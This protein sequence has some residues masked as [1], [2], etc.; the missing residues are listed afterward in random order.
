MLRFEDI[1][2]LLSGR[3]L[4]ANECNNDKR[5]LPYLIGASNI[6][7]KQIQIS[8]WTEFAKVISERGDILL[9]CKGTVGEIVLNTVGPIHIARQFMAIRSFQCVNAEYVEL[10]IRAIVE[11]IKAEARGVIPGISR[12]DIILQW[13]ALPPVQEQKK[14]VDVAKQL[15]SFVDSI[16]MMKENLTSNICKIKNKILDLAISGK[17]VTQCAEDK[18]AIELLKRINPDYKPCDTS[19]YENLP[20]GWTRLGLYQIITLL[21]GRV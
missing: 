3:D 13:I 10:Y 4:E 8:R 11:K 18:P 12:E 7:L 2:L 14:I 1:A 17:L 20:K 21:S 19:H 5:G 9:S 15:L 6:V 16:S